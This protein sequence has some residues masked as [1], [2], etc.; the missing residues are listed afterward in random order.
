MNYLFVESI[1]GR[2]MIAYAGFMGIPFLGALIWQEESLL[3]EVQGL[4]RVE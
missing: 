1:L 4:L 3:A 2:L